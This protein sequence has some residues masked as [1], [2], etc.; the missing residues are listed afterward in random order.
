MPDIDL[1]L[2]RFRQYVFGLTGVKLTPVQTLS[3]W[4]SVEAIDVDPRAK[5]WNP[6]DRKNNFEA[7]KQ[8]VFNVFL[9]AYEDTKSAAQAPKP[10]KGY[11]PD[12]R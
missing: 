12:G 4:S 11:N 5:N 3:I 9:A 6:K 8:H 2:E 7:L 10:V 1:K